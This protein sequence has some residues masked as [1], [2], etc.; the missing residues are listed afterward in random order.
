MGD[1]NW[2]YMNR[3]NSNNFLFFDE[4]CEKLQIEQLIMQ[5]TR[6]TLNRDSLLD[7]IFTNAKNVAHSGVLN[8]GISD[9][10]PVFLVKKRQHVTIEHEYIYKRS[11]KN[12]D[13]N[14]LADSLHELDWSVLD[15]LEDVN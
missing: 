1:L 8:Y 3:E 15:L 7:V 9:H 6:V 2:D 5:P 12:Y 10:L 4:L 11:F 13:V 14:S